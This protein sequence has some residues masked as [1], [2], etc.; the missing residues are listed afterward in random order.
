[1]E[2][3]KKLQLKKSKYQIYPFSA[4]MSWVHFLFHLKPKVNLK[5]T[6][7]IRGPKKP[8]SEKMGCS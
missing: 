8:S 6:Q 1:M 3:R 2:G 5:Y 7:S 4:Q